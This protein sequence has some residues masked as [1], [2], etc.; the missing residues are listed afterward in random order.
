MLLLSSLMICTSECKL[1][2][3]GKRVTTVTGLVLDEA[4][5][6][7]DSALLLLEPAGLARPGIILKETYTDS[8]GRYEIIVDVP[9][10]FGYTTVSLPSSG[11]KNFSLKYK[12]YIPY[13]N[14]IIPN[15]CCGVEIGSATS[16]DFVLL[17]K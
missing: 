15:T 5:Q 9:K 12:D 17:F 11:I 16:Y 4:Q 1:C 6:A 2:G 3:P 8:K 14:G 13:Q 7:V 10:E